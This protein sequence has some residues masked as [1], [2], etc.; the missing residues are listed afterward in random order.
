MSQGSERGRRRPKGF[1]SS[2]VRAVGYYL[3]AP[4]RW[5]EASQARRR[6]RRA[7]TGSGPSLGQRLQAPFNALA[8]FSGWIGQS[9]IWWLRSTNAKYLLLGLPAVIV[10]LS[11]MAVSSV[12][13]FTPEGSIVARYESIAGET[14]NEARLAEQAYAKSK[15]L[16]DLEVWKLSW[17]RAK[18]CQ[19]RLALLQKNADKNRYDLAVAEEGIALAYAEEAKRL[20]EQKETE[21]AKA[22]HEESLRRLSRVQSIMDDLAPANNRGYWKAHLWQANKIQGSR[23]VSLDRARLMERHLKRALDG[24]DPQD[25]PNIHGM[26]VRLYTALRE[27]QKAEP[28]IREAIKIHPEFR[29]Y[30]IEILASKGQNDAAM[31]SA[32]AARD[33]YERRIKE[34]PEDDNSRI[35]LAQVY[36]HLKQWQKAVEILGEG[37]QLTNNPL[38]RQLI[39]SVY[40]LWLKN[41]RSQSQADQA[42]QLALINSALKFDAANPDMLQ[43]L[44]DLSKGTGKEAERAKDLITLLSNGVMPATLHMVLG[45]DAWRTGDYSRARIHLDQAFKLDPTLT[46]VG[47]NLAWSYANQEPKDLERALALANSVVAAKP[48]LPQYR[49]TRGQILAQMNRWLD[50]LY[51][52]ELA[53]P[54]MATDEKLHR[55]LATVY[56]KLEMPEL[57][58]EHSKIAERIAKSEIAKNP[59]EV[60]QRPKAGSVVNPNTA[61]NAPEPKGDSKSAAAGKDA[62]AKPATSKAAPKDGTPEKGAKSASPSSP[63]TKPAPP[64]PAPTSKP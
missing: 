6:R 62:A 16:R 50:A 58:G 59:L 5:W 14:T 39:G 17:Q 19:E 36:L 41:T 52:L 21:K 44:M 7:E 27:P 3:T 49:D 9:F 20:E 11:A 46:D 42:L 28:H 31:R 32:E 33:Y 12:A 54:G 37:L 34:A 25:V 30:E 38:Y 15:D 35:K 29:L 40:V 48:A 8:R 57:A 22:A 2:L 18:V 10:F 64:G 24:A 63:A 23:E 43:I 60:V 13:Y 53:L 26:L 55:T 56:Q 45:N 61:P 47:N 4:V 51:E 1:F